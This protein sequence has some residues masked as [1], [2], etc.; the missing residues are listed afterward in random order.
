MKILLVEDDAGIGRVISQSLR[1]RG[2]NVDWV[3][4][5][6]GVAQK[7]KLKNYNTIIL[8]LLLPDADGLNIC[9]DI[10]KLDI[11]TPVL[12]LSSRSNLDDRIDGFRAGADDYLIK[13]F[14]YQ[15]LIARIGALLRRDKERRPDP[16]VIGRLR[17]DPETK[18]VFWGDVQM[19][20]SGKPYNLLVALASAR[21]EFV[22]RSTLIEEIWGEDAT[23]SDNA[24]DV[25]ASSL[26]RAIAHTTKHVF[27][28]AGRRRGYSLQVTVDYLGRP[29]SEIGQ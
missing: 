1:G 18:Q 2:L 4:V 7:A 14:A 28:E 20:I 6:A 21:G 15:E 16:I 22:D 25:C 24:L 3:R 13:P 27:V 8:D 17:I 9:T 26:R 29:W 19:P 5:G 11:K 12:M 10:R 23:V